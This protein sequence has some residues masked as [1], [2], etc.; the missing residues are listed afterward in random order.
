MSAWEGKK[1]LKLCLLCI[2]SKRGHTEDQWSLTLPEKRAKVILKI[3]GVVEVF[4]SAFLLQLIL[5]TIPEMELNVIYELVHVRQRQD[6]L[7][8]HLD[9]EDREGEER[10]GEDQ[11]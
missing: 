2:T 8:A 5:I 6:L 1:K 4:Q 9:R 7:K 11:L 3:I 10:R